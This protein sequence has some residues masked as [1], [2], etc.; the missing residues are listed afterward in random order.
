MPP[1]QASC[2]TLGTPLL[3]LCGGGGHLSTCHPSLH[4]THEVTHAGH[5]EGSGGQT[6]S[7]N[8]ASERACLSR[9][10]AGQPKWSETMSSQ[11]NIQ[12]WL[13]E[14]ACSVAEEDL[15]FGDATGD[16]TRGWALSRISTPNTPTGKRGQWVLGRAGC[17]EEEGVAQGPPHTAHPGRGLPLLA[18]RAI[19][20][21]ASDRFV[22]VC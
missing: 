2:C 12:I 14:W 6:S 15:G 3:E 4:L 16:G 19:K 21:D 9:R 5:P 10:G 1:R 17:S 11:R 20:N 8:T 18:L 7:P 13:A 22:C